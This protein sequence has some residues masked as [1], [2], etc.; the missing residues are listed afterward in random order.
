[1]KRHIKIYSKI[2]SSN[3][4]T[5]RL[6]SSGKSVVVGEGGCA[7]SK[8]VLLLSFNSNSVFQ[9][10]KQYDQNIPFIFFMFSCFHPGRRAK[11]SL[12]IPN[13][14]MKSESERYFWKQV[15]TNYSH[16]CLL[17][18]ERWITCVL[19]KNLSQ[20]LCSSKAS[21]L[22]LRTN[23]TKCWQWWEQIRDQIG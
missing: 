10:Q 6:S 5:R 20:I 15:T 8:T 13:T 3:R 18:L 23:Y 14:A 7:D 21:W 2:L 17:L 4:L 22:H 16:C 19:C 12:V 11:S 1:M 9:T